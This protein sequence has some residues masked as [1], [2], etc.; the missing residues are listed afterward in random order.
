M[1]YCAM[2]DHIIILRARAVLEE[3]GH[4]QE[5]WTSLHNPQAV[6]KLW[7]QDLE[8]WGLISSNLTWIRAWVNRQGFGI[9]DLAT[10][11]AAGNQGRRETFVMNGPIT[12][13]RWLRLFA[14]VSTSA[15][16]GGGGACLFPGRGSVC[17]RNI[18][19]KN[20][21]LV[22]KLGG[23]HELVAA[24]SAGDFYQKDERLELY[25]HLWEVDWFVAG[26]AWRFLKGSHYTTQ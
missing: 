12:G 23:F 4:Y 25:W 24:D 13:W 18:R 26:F 17:C 2:F 15:V 21:S 22:Q 7:R 1:R 6:V 20:S 11:A 19:T 14:K 5:G 9:A 16:G 8:E 10:V 3:I